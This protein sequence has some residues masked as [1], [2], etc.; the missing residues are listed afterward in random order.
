MQLRISGSLLIKYIFLDARTTTL[1]TEYF[2]KMRK[3]KSR[4][5]GQLRPN[6]KGKEQ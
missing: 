5:K 2:S 6:R 1:V 4:E 3:K